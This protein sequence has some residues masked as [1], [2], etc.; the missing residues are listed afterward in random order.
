MARSAEAT[1]GGAYADRWNGG[2]SNGP[3]DP[4]KEHGKHG[5][6]ARDGERE[7]PEQNLNTVERALSVAAGGALAAYGLKRKDWA[8]VAAGVVGGFLVERGV[9]GHCVA[10]DALGLTSVGDDEGAALPHR[11]EGLTRQHGGS[12]SVD[13]KS[14]KRV[15]QTFTIF[16]RHP[17]ELYDYWRNLENL[18]RILRH[19]ESVKELDNRRSHWVAK[20]PAGQTV[21]WDAEIINDVPGEVIAWR[22]LPKA[23]V[24]NAGAVTFREAPGGRGT[25][26]KV[27]L[28]YEPP[29]GK[30]GVA[31]AKLFGEE[32]SVQV[33]EDLRRYKNL[34]EAGEIPVS[35]NPGQGKPPH[36][37]F[38]A[39][40]N[41]GKTGGDVRAAQQKAVGDA[42]QAV[43]QPMPSDQARGANST[44][45]P[46]EGR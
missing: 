18:P 22:S 34:M 4:E 17:G 46:K 14:A 8:G 44:L 33:R 30:L 13:A 27:N 15:I 39:Q 5:A 9:T 11:E 19:L 21:E 2:R 42:H 20:A 16:G 1:Y 35:Y 3:S 41:Q 23:S 43:H 7:G 38:D 10:Y 36:Q 12:G 29:L 26:V 37:T 6:T 32:P 45:T 25:E 28:E 40:V 24:P 31:V